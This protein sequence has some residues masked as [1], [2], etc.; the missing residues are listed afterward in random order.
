MV[1]DD[2]DPDSVSAGSFFTNP[3]LDAARAEELAIRVRERLGEGAA[4]PTFPDPAGVKVAAAWLIERAGFSKGYSPGGGVAISK[5][6]AL[7][8]VAR[9]GATTHALLSLAREIE[10]GVERAF[11]VRLER[12]PVLVGP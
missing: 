7:A 12:E 6:H 10:D 1:L 8:L 2:R 5:K 11:G 9:E 4:P 3:I